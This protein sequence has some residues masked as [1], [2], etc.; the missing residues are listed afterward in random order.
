MVEAEH[1]SDEAVEALNARYPVVR[2]IDGGVEIEGDDV[3][4]FDIDDCLRPMGVII[5]ASYNKKVTLDD[6]FLQLTGKELR[7]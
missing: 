4:L 3:R 2:R 1:L 6:V 7:E 5:Q